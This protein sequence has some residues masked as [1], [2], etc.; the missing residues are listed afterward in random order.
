MS[1]LHVKDKNLLGKKTELYL[2]DLELK[3]NFFNKMPEMR[4]LKKMI[5]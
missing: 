4:T 2:Y 1:D 3:E 5:N